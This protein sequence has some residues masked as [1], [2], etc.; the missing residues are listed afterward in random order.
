MA[1][2]AVAQSS[3]L[4]RPLLPTAFQIEANLGSQ[5]QV[6]PGGFAQ[7]GGTDRGGQRKLPSLLCFLSPPPFYFTSF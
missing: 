5:R 7:T 2:S 3:L 6:C 4:P 1:L